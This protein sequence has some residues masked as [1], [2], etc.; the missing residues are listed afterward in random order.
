MPLR[1][2]GVAVPQRN[3]PLHSSEAS[4]RRLASDFAMKPNNVIYISQDAE[5]RACELACVLLKQRCTC[6]R[7]CAEISAR[8]SCSARNACHG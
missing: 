2:L 3:E 7:A 1:Y 5:E 8:G 4:G 6:M